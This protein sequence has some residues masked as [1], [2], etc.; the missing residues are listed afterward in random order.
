MALMAFSGTNAACELERVKSGFPAD[1]TTGASSPVAL[2]VTG[3]CASSDFGVP[4]I[5]A[6][7]SLLS[8]QASDTKGLITG[9][10]DS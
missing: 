4:R 8:G 6:R 1:S 5:H 10:A 2:P 9:V 3:Y 7:R